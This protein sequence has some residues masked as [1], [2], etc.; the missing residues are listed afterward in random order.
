MKSQ[1]PLKHHYLSWHYHDEIIT[2]EIEY[3][4]KYYSVKMTLPYRVAIAQ[5]SLTF[6]IP[7][8]FGILDE[9]EI[10]I[11]GTINLIPIAKKLCE[12]WIDHKDANLNRMLIAAT[13]L[14]E[15]TQSL[16]I[17]PMK[18]AIRDLY[19]QARDQKK[20]YKASKISQHEYQKSRKEI[21]EAI[22]MEINRIKNYV[23]GFV[24]ERFAK[25][26]D[27]S[28]SEQTTQAWEYGETIDPE[29]FVTGYLIEAMCQKV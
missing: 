25:A 12:Q 4:S 13:V 15:G 27:M 14:H 6:S 20:L 23:E 10:S 9:N 28:I 22:D 26:V 24:R 11:G 2:A 7:T 29:D 17:E 16:D 21:R 18:K 8:H 1:P 5:N 19:E 3:W